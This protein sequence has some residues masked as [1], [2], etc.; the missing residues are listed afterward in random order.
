MALE[1]GRNPYQQ[2]TAVQHAL[3][4]AITGR[5]DPAQRAS[6]EEH[7]YIVP[8][9]AVPQHVIAGANKL[10]DDWL[11]N[12]GGGGVKGLVAAEGSLRVAGALDQ[13]GRA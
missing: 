8:K 12:G 4:V 2:L 5:M 10:Y 9:D 1:E 7:G 11:A 6:F 13:A 3:Q